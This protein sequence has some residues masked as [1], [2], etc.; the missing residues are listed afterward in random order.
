MTNINRIAFLL[1]SGISINAGLPK[2]LD[3]TTR[4]LSG[5]CITRHTDGTYYFNDPNESFDPLFDDCVWRI[6]L[7]LKRIQDEIGSYYRT[8]RHHV[9][10]YEELCYIC[11]QIDDAITGEYDNPVIQSFIDKLT[12]YVNQLT[13][14]RPDSI[15]EWDFPSSLSRMKT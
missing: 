4:V 7:L 10:N 3:I 5:D 8:D 13:E 12:P 14:L 6:T 15:I 1:G 11:S 9:T 2:T